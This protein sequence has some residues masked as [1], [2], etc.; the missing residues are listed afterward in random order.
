MIGLIVARSKN[1][2]IGK[3]GRLPWKIDG[4]QEQFKDLTTGNAVV[5]GRKTYEE[6]GHPL[7]DRMNIVVS[8]SSVYCGKNL[9]TVRSLREAINA[10]KGAD[11]FICGGYML[12]KEAIPLVDKMYITEIDLEIKDGDVFFPEFDKND[13]L[14]AVGETAGGDVKY[15]RTVYTRKCNTADFQ[16]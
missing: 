10:A 6:I 5:F 7:P 16:S 14:L 4:E 1:N 12:Y 8:T 11:V 15:T 3:G 13:F 9:T 2:V